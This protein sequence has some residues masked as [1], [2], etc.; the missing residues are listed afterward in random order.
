E[1]LHTCFVR[2]K[3]SSACEVVRGRDGIERRTL[4][5]ELDEE[6]AVEN[7]VPNRDITERVHRELDRALGVFALDRNELGD[8]LRRPRVERA[9]RPGKV[10]TAVAPEEEPLHVAGA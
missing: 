2:G 4:V 8:S 6:D 5:R 10:V 9:R 3:V 1:Q 7:A